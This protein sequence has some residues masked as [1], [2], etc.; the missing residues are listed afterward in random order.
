[1]RWPW[2]ATAGVPSRRN[3]HR[4][5]HPRGLGGRSQRRHRR[6]AISDDARG[7]AN[8]EYQRRIMHADIT[9]ETTLFGMSW[10]L[11]HRVVLNAATRRWCCN[12]GR[13]KALPS[14]LNR[15]SRPLSVLGYLDAG[16]LLRLQS[17][18]RPLF[19]PL[20]LLRRCPIH[21]WTARHY[22]PRYGAGIND[23]HAPS[24]RR[25]RPNAWLRRSG[26][27][28]RPAEG[29]RPSSAASAAP[30]TPRHPLTSP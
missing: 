2:P 15:M 3:R 27:R 30:R 6:D 18:A 29:P 10:P 13:A 4:R 25:S 8:G 19:T 16:A 26:S 20:A 23:I 12:D 14:A 11:R 24:R 28:R 9:I 1:M 5:R 17:P 21:G 22:T 7:N